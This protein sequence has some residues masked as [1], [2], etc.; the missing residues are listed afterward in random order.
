M[1]LPYRSSGTLSGEPCCTHFFKLACQFST[2][3]MDLETYPMAEFTK[4]R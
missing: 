3:V 2:T 4:N 1:I